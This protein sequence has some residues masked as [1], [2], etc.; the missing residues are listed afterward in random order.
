MESRA[1]H[2][3][4]VM[5]NPPT[6]IGI[7]GLGFMGGTH[8][9]AYLRADADGHPCKVVAICDKKPERL[10]GEGKGV[11]NLATALKDFDFKS[12]RPYTSIDELVKDPEIDVIDICTPTDSHVEHAITALQAGK[13]VIVEKPVALSAEGIRKIDA[14][15]KA[16]GKI[17]LPAQCMRFWPTWEWLK[18][19][20]DDKRF[21]RLKALNFQRLGSMPTWSEFFMDVNR[22]GGASI[23]LHIHDCDFLYHCLGRPTAVTSAGHVNHLTTIYH[24]DDTSLHVTAQG[25]WLTPN[26]PFR[27]RYIAE[28][29][30]ASV[31]FDIGRTPPLLLAKD[32]AATP[33]ETP[34]LNGYDG[35]IRHVLELVRCAPGKRPAQ[36]ATLEEAADVAIILETEQYAAECGRRVQIMWGVEEPPGH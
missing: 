30:Q 31:D 23:D 33:I 1:G 3:C 27:M 17:C 22:S 7:I 20:I 32:G 13:H 34:A 2:P 24:F 35:E 9:A 6:K 11:G 5:N 18:G 36:R 8:I 15:A 25:G 21:G 19:A 28:F 29:E 14:V 10:R 26:T 16:S 12:A 4:Y